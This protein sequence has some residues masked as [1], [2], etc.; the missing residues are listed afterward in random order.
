MK[1]TGS[2]KS[3]EGSEQPPLLYIDGCNAQYYN[4]FG[5]RFDTLL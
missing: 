2:K 3:G 5:K 1:K 4:H